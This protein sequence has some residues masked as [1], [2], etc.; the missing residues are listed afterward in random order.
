MMIAQQQ[1]AAQAAA[2][3]EERARQDAISRQTMIANQMRASSGM[4]QLKNWCTRSNWYYGTQDF[5]RRMM[6]G[7]TMT[8]GGINV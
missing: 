6:Q 4:P 2:E 5:K 3:R 7:M 1:A 8:L